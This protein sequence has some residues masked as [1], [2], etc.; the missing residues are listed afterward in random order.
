MGNWGLGILLLL[1]GVLT[2]GSIAWL[3]VAFNNRSPHV[4]KKRGPDAGG[5]GLTGAGKPVP[6]RPTPRQYLV[7]AK[8]LPPSEKTYLLQKN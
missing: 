4:S 8:G 2:F 3:V 5:A 1:L 7:A 6:V